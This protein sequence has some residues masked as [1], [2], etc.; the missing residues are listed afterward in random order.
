MNGE[1]ALTA[2]VVPPA[3]MTSR[4]WYRPYANSRSLMIGPDS[5]AI[6]S[7][8]SDL[9]ESLSDRYV[10]GESFVRASGSQLK[11][12]PP[13]GWLPPDL[14]MALMKPPVARPNSA[15]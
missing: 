13:C 7:R 5:C 11:V 4:N 2:E 1:S 6:A 9:D 14:V 15:E 8:R 3:S 10:F 12:T